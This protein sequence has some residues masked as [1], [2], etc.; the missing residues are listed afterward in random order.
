MV[1]NFRMKA[2][3]S[4]ATIPMVCQIIRLLLNRVVHEDI[5][6]V[7]KF[8]QEL[9]LKCQNNEVLKHFE[10]SSSSDSR[11]TSVQHI[12]FYLSQ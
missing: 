8:L 1:C 7:L 3:R 12:S 4:T 11:T 6:L 10:T 5:N 2:N 9:G